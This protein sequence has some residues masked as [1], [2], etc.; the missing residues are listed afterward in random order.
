MAADKRPLLREVM[1]LP[2]SVSTSDY[3][4]KLAEAITPDGARRALADY[5][6]TDRLLDNYDEALGLIK[7]ALDGHTS[8]AIYLHG[9]FGSGKSHF[10]AVLYA[11]LS[12]NPAARAMPAFDPLLTRQRWLADGDKKFLLVPFHMLGAKSI[13]QRV[14][15]RYVTHVQQ[16]HPDAPTPRVYRTDALFDDIRAQRARLGDEAFLAGIS[17]D[18]GSAAVNRWGKAFGWTTELLDTAL[19]APEVHE[20]SVPLDLTNP[21]TPAELRAKLVQDASTTLFPGFT[22]N[23]GE[24]ADGFISLDAGLAVIAE[25]ARDL[26]YDG[27]ILFLD[28]LILWLAGLIQDQ[29]FVGAEAAKIT[30][31]VE[32]GDARRAIPVVSFIARQR[33]LRELVG[34]EMS[35]AAEAAIQDS[36]SLASGRFDKINLE[37]RNL[38]QIAHARLLQPRD[39]DARRQVDESF[40]ASRKVRQEV[41]DTWLGSAKGTTGGDEESF[42]LSYPFSPAFMDTLVHIS[43]ALQRNRTG[44]KLMGELLAEHRDELRLGDIVPLGDLYPLIA[45]GGDRPFTEGTAVIFTAADKLYKTKLRPYLLM[46]HEISEDEAARYRRDPDSV[47]DPALAIR[48]RAFVGDDRIAT[49]LLLS[50][51]VPSVPA[52]NELSL[53]RLV[54]LNYGSVLTRIPGGEAGILKQRL[55]DW[56]SRFPEIKLT[57]TE[58]NPAVRL[59]LSD[60]DLDSVLQNADVNNN[61]GNRQALAKRLL[62]EEL[63]LKAGPGDYDELHFVWRGSQR[64]AET[65]FG[66]IADVDSLTDQDLLPQIDGRWKIVI[67]LPWDEGAYG[68]RDD[69]NR[70]DRLRERQGTPSRTA[71]WVPS[72]LSTKAYQDLQRLVVIDRALADEHRFNSVYAIHLNPD[73]RARA[74]ALLESQR[75]NLT[76]QVKAAFKQAYGL[77]AKDAASVD[78]GYDEHL[79]ALPEVEKLTLPV[80]DSLYNGIRHIA[81]QLLAYQYPAHPDFDPEN[82]GAVVKP[83]DAKRVFQHIR[84]AAESRDGR[85]E[86]P[87]P[88]RKLM[89]RVAVP[90]ALGQQ[91]EA[92]FELSRRWVEFF[93]TEARRDGITGDFSFVKLSDWTDRPEPRGLDSVLVQLVIASFAEVDDRVWTR[94]GT[95]VDESLEFIA[96]PGDAL[97]SQ[98]LPS[99]ADWEQAQQRF[100]VIFG[101]PT[102]L[103]LRG[104]MVNQFAQQIRGAARRLTEDAAELV[105]QLEMHERWLNLD[106]TDEA[107][108]LALA[109]RSLELLKTLTGASGGSPIAGASGAKRTVESLARF[110]LGAVSAD[111][112][113]SSIKQAR[114]V[115]EALNRA[116]WATLAL[117]DGLG[118]EGQQLLGSLRAVAQGD[119]RTGDLA[120]ALQDTASQILALLRREQRRAT[121]PAAVDPAPPRPTRPGDVSLTDDSGNPP[122]P[123]SHPRAAG[124]PRRSGGGRTTAAR[125]AAELTAEIAELAAA[126]PDA[127]IEISWRVVE[128]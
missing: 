88:D 108:R 85:V 109:R 125:V 49:T 71:G 112:F 56:S 110:E 20:S 63:G 117:A 26:G 120:Q 128:D 28:E 68:P 45:R 38:P 102:P 50:A 95:A 3:V 93:Q 58:A 47:T 62:R 61:P 89:Q 123:T 82:V 1:N 100:K 19:A 16:L 31:L 114:P 42:R 96:R 60:I 127:R 81:A 75:E 6:V 14:L 104:R 11:L 116:S 107:G 80:G 46:T 7:S 17:P 43:N 84:A 32:G 41:W 90:L 9:S 30:N 36:L 52:L 72:H 35:G 27:L 126:E 37:D 115:A 76:K 67:D 103:L 92:Y 65:V 119:Q 59:E 18:R 64:V 97:R 111:R 78:V 29:K 101:E 25:H 51:L 121:P 94:A 44:M 66:N 5:V 74:K 22:K 77:A 39:D 12:G 91:K 15:G 69:L 57:G 86:I 54:A 33:D 2:E 53:R 48:C 40:A 55:D 23:A 8:K 79:R 10:M 106:G 118:A 113:G 87:A 24:N 105:R 124:T 98:P 70:L 4:L 99:Q 73:N 21:K 83:A 122:V 13:E 34:E